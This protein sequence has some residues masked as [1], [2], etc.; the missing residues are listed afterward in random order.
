M[1]MMVVPAAIASFIGDFFLRNFIPHIMLQLLYAG[2]MF[3][4]ATLLSKSASKI[5][6]KNAVIDS[7]KALAD[8]TKPRN[9]LYILTGIISGLMASLLGLGAAIVVAPLL[10]MRAKFSYE[11]A[12]VMAVNL[13][14]VS[15]IFALGTEVVTNTLPYYLGF[16]V[17]LGTVVGSFFGILARKHIKPIT[18]FNGIYVVC[19]FLA[20]SMLWVALIDSL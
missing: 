18:V 20:F 1:R 19:L 14:I 12:I 13:T 3:W 2:V 6:P 15:C 11:Y 4:S 7:D 16:L 9:F 17:S 8:Q 10:I 5:N